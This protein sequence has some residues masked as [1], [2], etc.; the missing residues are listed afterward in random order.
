V[1]RRS[2]QRT[3]PSSLGWHH[4]RWIAINTALIAATAYL[5][6]HSPIPRLLVGRQPLKQAAA[7]NDAW[8]GIAPATEASTGG[9]ATSA[10]KG[11][12]LSAPSSTPAP[13]PDQE[14]NRLRR[15]QD[16]PKPFYIDAATA[17]EI[18]VRC[19]NGRAFKAR[20]HNDTLVIDEDHSY[21]CKNS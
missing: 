11:P 4:I 8:A 19:V 7:Q 10:R 9:V 15:E 13:L 18:G 17:R 12:V 2:A 6:V 16:E 3:P 20:K 1:A 21:R 5:Y 14:R